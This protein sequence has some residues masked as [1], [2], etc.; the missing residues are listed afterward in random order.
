MLSKSYKLLVKLYVVQQNNNIPMKTSD[1]FDS[2]L[3]H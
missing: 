1:K 2:L 3:I